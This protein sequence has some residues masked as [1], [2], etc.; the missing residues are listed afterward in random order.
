M[1]WLDI[2]IEGL[3]GVVSFIFGVII[4]SFFELM[5]AAWWWVA[6]TLAVVFII[7][8][9]YTILA[10]RLRFNWL[11]KVFH[12]ERDAESEHKLSVARRYAFGIGL[13]LAFLITRIVPP[14]DLLALL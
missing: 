11:D 2:V 4:A 8:F 9:G 12:H 7:Y 1:N 3:T 10:A 14:S 5:G 6:L 13:V